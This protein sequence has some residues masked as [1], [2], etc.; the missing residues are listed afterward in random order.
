MP[1]P[2]HPSRQPR[3]NPPLRLDSSAVIRHS[4]DTSPSRSSIQSSREDTPSSSVSNTPVVSTRAPSPEKKPLHPGNS[5]TFLTALAAQERQV[6][7]L[8]EELQKAEGELGRL[9]KQWA[10]HEAA[11]KR[12]ELRHLEQLQPIKSTLGGL[13]ESPDQDSNLAMRDV[14]R[15]IMAAPTV[16]PSKRTVFSG[17]RHTRTLSL[18]SPSDTVA[19][20]SP[21]ACSAHLHIPDRGL[22]NDAIVPT[23]IYEPRTST[24]GSADL[25]ERYEG[26][27]KDMILETGKQLVG[28]FRQGLWTFFEDLRQVTVGDEAAG[29][30]NQRYQRCS[31]TESI[32]HT[33]AK[34]DRVSTTKS[35]PVNQ[36]EIVDSE[37]LAEKLETENSGSHGPVETHKKASLASPLIST[38]C[39]NPGNTSDNFSESD[40]GQSCT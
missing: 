2:A 3:I 34:R 9:K 8:K 10:S 21:P 35:G 13:V 18:L 15:R 39:A 26:P 29:A 36:G 7:E 33:R 14:D 17:S 16:K 27:P 30:S 11:K 25:K 38:S 20:S 31:P 24:D 22:V 1:G 5:S 19:G 32:A 40:D 4:I 6:L 37:D 28:D 12:D 23:T